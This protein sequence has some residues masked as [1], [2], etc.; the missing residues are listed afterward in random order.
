MYDLMCIHKQR[1]IETGLTA[2][3]LIRVGAVGMLVAVNRLCSS[4]GPISGVRYSAL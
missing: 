3:G 4:C 1:V 2:V